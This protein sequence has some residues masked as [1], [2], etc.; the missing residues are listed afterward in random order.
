MPD[1]RFFFEKPV[2][3]G[4]RNYGEDNKNGKPTRRNSDEERIKRPQAVHKADIDDADTQRKEDGTPGVEIDN[5][6][7]GKNIEEREDDRD[8]VGE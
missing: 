4:R 3:I 1:P 7:D 8:A 5:A 2:R 6:D